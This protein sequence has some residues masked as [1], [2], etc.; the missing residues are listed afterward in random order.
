MHEDMK[1]FDSEM[2][3]IVRLFEDLDCRNPFNAALEQNLAED[4]NEI[5]GED[6]QEDKIDVN[7]DFVINTMMAEDDVEGYLSMHEITSKHRADIILFLCQQKINTE[8]FIKFLK[9]MQ[10]ETFD[11]EKTQQWCD[12]DLELLGEGITLA[13]TEDGKIETI[14]RNYWII[15]ENE[16]VNDCRIYS[17]GDNSKVNIN[18]IDF[19]LVTNSPDNLTELI[20]KLKE[21]D[22]Y[23]HNDNLNHNQYQEKEENKGKRKTRQSTKPKANEL[24]KDK[25]KN[26][27]DLIKIL[28][29]LKPQFIENNDSW[30]KRQTIL[31]RKMQTLER[32]RILITRQRTRRAEKE[33]DYS[34]LQS[35]R[36]TR[37]GLKSLT[38]TMDEENNLDKQSSGSGNDPAKIQFEVEEARRKE[39]MEAEKLAREERL[40]KREM[41]KEY[42]R[43]KAQRKRDKK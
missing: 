29:D 8:E 28:E 20:A 10:D 18:E 26:N 40:Q 25:I 14:T 5:E 2:L 11:K 21:A 3:A 37:G 42:N 13:Q 22:N 35:G 36:L 1:I 4:L 39:K 41:M 15:S 17:S 30:N 9:R 12:T 24:P 32:S 34:L 38:K 19:K 23:L 6:G 43:L 31:A 27:E 16:Y 33:L 7:N